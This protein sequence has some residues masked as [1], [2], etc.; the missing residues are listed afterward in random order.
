[1][2]Q[3]LKVLSTTSSGGNE[4][5]LV[6]V[7]DISTIKP[8]PVGDRSPCR[9]LISLRSNDR[10]PVWCTETVEELEAALLHLGSDVVPQIA[11]DGYR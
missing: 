7:N 9:S 6:N 1:M 4:V 10:F 11:A 2:S 3:F 8:S 5:K